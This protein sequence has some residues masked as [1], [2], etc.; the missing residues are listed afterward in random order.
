MNIKDEELL[1]TNQKEE[2]M[3]DLYSL[4]DLVLVVLDEKSNSLQKKYLDSIEKMFG[5]KINEID[6]SIGFL[7]KHVQ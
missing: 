7:R 2:T 5:I 1:I 6:F 4:H 3:K